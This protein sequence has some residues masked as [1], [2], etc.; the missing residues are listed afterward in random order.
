MESARNLRILAKLRERVRRL[1]KALLQAKGS[2]RRR[3]EE[4]E[5]LGALLERRLAFDRTKGCV[6]EVGTDVVEQPIL[7]GDSQAAVWLREFVDLVV[8]MDPSN[9]NRAKA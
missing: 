1:K 5:F 3:E 8:L 4:I 7:G 9:P 6:V 2:I